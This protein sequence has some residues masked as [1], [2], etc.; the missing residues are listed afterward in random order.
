MVSSDKDPK[1][2]STIRIALAVFAIPSLILAYM[3]GAMV[4][5]GNY[6]GIDYFEWV[7][8]MIGIFAIYIAI[9]GKRYF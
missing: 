3:I 8:S 9:T 6:Q 4:L 1:L 2:S 5:S 7:Y